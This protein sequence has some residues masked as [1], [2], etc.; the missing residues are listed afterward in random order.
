M[1]TLTLDDVPDELFDWLK[2]QAHTRQHSVNREIVNLL[3]NLREKARDNSIITRHEKYAA[4]L[5]I[6]Q[7]CS[8]LPEL[9]IRSADEILGYDNH[10]LLG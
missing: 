4:I 2:Q 1:K 7:R 5:A 6:S 8:E 9:D 10:G 3:E